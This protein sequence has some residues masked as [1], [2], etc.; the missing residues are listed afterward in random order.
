MNNDIT[1]QY[2]NQ[3]WENFSKEQ[4]R[5]M[6]DIKSG[7]EESEIQTIQKQLTQINAIMMGLMRL[8]NIKKKASSNF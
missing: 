1:E 8:R 7:K 4:M 5:L 6:G 3:T 2:L